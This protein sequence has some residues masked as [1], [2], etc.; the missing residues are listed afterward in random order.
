[1]LELGRIS[2]SVPS[3]IGASGANRDSFTSFADMLSSAMENVA[4]SDSADK[5]S[6]IALMTG[7]DINLHDVTI[8]AEQADIV[9]S[10]TLKIQNKVIDAYTEIMRMQV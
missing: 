10:L 9:L 5:A 7:Q 2:S 1:M 3:A 8:A 4:A 6:N